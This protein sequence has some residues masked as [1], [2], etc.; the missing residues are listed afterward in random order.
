MWQREGRKKSID[1]HLLREI[2]EKVLPE[3]SSSTVDIRFAGGEPTL[4][5][6]D[7]LTQ[8][9]ELCREI[10]YKWN[11]SITFSMQTNGTQITASFAA[12]LASNKVTVGISLDGP[13]HINE[14]TRGHTE[15]TLRGFAHLKNAFGYSPGVIVTV[16]KN[17]VAFMPEIIDY[18]RSLEVHYFRANL[19]GASRKDAN[20]LMPSYNQWA[21]ARLDILSTISGYEGKIIEHNT[22]VMTKTLVSSVLTSNDNSISGGCGGCSDIRCPAGSSLL[23]FDQSGKAYPCPRSNTS[24]NGSFGHILDDSFSKSWDQE[25]TTLDKSMQE[26]NS[27]CLSCPAM[28]V[29][30]YGCHAFNV[31][32]DNF[33]SSNCNASKMVYMQL[34]DYFESVATVFLLTLWR[35]A[36]RSKQI[37]AHSIEAGFLPDSRLVADLTSKL[38]TSSKFQN[39]YRI[40]IDEE[41]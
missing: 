30:D 5:G 23:Y 12:L 3:V 13:P 26:F 40:K 38:K 19:M 22:S 41:I 25:I 33:F 20:E 32:Q 36:I 1:N 7:W 9:F 27:E 18:L 39:P 16:S 4:A 35:D 14:I 37:D 11:K 29:C 31:S 24:I 15:A 10:G 17:N 21:K 28:I 8:A 2:L 6:A 34:S